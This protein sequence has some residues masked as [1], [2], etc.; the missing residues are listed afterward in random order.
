MTAHVAILMGVYNGAKFI[1]QQLDSFVSQT[2][3]DWRLIASDDG[4]RDASASLITAFA[5]EV[6]QTISIVQGP[7]AG[8][9]VN[10]LSLL[11]DLEGDPDFVA[12][13]DQDDVWLPEKLERAIAALSS[14][15]PDQPMLLGTAS[16]IVDD[17]LNNKVRSPRFNRLPSF[18][19]ALVQS[20][21]G[22]N[23]MLLNRAGW[24][25]AKAA[26]AE[27][28]AVGGPFTHDWWLY[29][30]ISGAGGKVVRDEQPSLLYRQHGENLFGTNIGWM[31]S[32]LRLKQVLDGQL[33][34]WCAQNTKALMESA[35]RLTPENREILNGF[36]SMS[37]LRPG[38]RLQKFRHLGLYRQGRAS[39]KIVEVAAYLGRI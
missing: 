32:A 7:K 20:V 23:T 1:E 34:E 36:A 37:G 30:V 11:R 33:K 5:L 15:S 25:L 26:A 4:S 31:A 6:P 35:H 38:A 19:N 17:E 21:A 2:H 16:Y 22:G 39:Q 13:S 8:V 10:F 14:F 3:Q 18:R 24:Q 28:L 29:Q 9:A 27:A 12:F